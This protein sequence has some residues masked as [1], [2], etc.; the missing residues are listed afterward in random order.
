MTTLKRISESSLG[1]AEHRAELLT[2]ATG[3]ATLGF[4]VEERSAD[5]GRGEGRTAGG[6]S[7]FALERT[8]CPFEELAQ[9]T[10][11]VRQCTCNVRGL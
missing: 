2:D 4:G 9:S 3:A 10:A 1:I 5:S 8:S 6:E 7:T 11:L